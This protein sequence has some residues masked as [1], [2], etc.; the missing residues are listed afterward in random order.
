MSGNNGSTVSTP[1]RASGCRPRPLIIA[2]SGYGPRP[3]L[4]A[5]AEEYGFDIEFFADLDAALAEVESRAAPVLL[6]DIALCPSQLWRVRA[7]CPNTF[8]LAFVT[9]SCAKLSEPADEALNL[10]DHGAWGRL[11]ARCGAVSLREAYRGS[12]ARSL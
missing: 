5:M 3:A 12:A 10:L 8:T 2:V 1:S 4:H 7:T 9:E 11:A 6:L